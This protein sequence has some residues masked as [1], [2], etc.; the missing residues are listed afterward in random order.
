M[1]YVRKQ[2]L[3]MLALIVP[4]LAFNQ[5]HTKELFASLNLSLA[6]YYISGLILNG[7]LAVYAVGRFLVFYRIYIDESRSRPSG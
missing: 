7:A 2:S 3:I 1:N 6:T 4:M 5:L